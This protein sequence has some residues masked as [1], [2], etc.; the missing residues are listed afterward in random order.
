MKVYFWG[1]RGS[2]PISITEKMIKK[3]I[4]NAL[5]KSLNSNL[6][7]ENDVIAFMRNNQTFSDK[8]TFGGN[9]SCVEIKDD[10]FSQKIDDYV[11]CDAGSG[12]RDFGDYIT[13]TEKTGTFNIFI[14][15]LHWDHIHGFPFF[16]PAYNPENSINIYGCHKELNDAFI[17]QQSERHFPV[18][19]DSMA[20]KINFKVLRVDEEIEVSGYKVNAIL[21][22]HPG[23]SFG[24]SF[25]K[26]GKKVIYSTDSEHLQ[27]AYKDDYPFYDFFKNADLLIFDGQYLLLENVDSKEGWGHSNSLIG[28]EL[29]SKSNVKKLCV[30]HHEH[31]YSDEQ[32]E[33]MLENTKRYTE[34]AKADNLLIEYAFDGLEI[35]V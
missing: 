31:T 20:S 10:K 22:N 33:K 5:V 9:T 35:E 1:T 32:L 25:Q 18:P 12:I 29:A 15:H 16:T 17:N 23:D 19:L 30:F 34:H 28:V 11:I 27:D 2:L 3:K 21:Q 26:N 14:S 4:R 24:Y 13:K 8:G 7:S 6:K